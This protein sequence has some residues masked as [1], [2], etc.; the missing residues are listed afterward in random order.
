[1]QDTLILGLDTTTSIQAVNWWG[2]D[3]DGDVIGYWVQWT[4][5]DTA[6]FTT[7]ESAVFYLP[8][9]TEFDI[10]SLSVTAVDNDSLCD[11]TPAIVSFPVYNSPPSVEWKLNSLPTSTRTEDSVHYSFTHHSFFW[12][13]YDLDGLQTLT[14][15]YYALDDTSSWN[16]LPGDRR[17]VMLTGIDPGPHR[18][19]LKVKDI[20]GAESDVITFPDPA[21]E[22]SQVRRW[23][24]KEPIGNVL[25]VNDY[26][27]DQLIYEHQNL[28]TGILDDLVGSDGYSVWEDRQRPAPIRPIRSPVPRRYRKKSQQ[29]F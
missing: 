20:A 24:V 29:L 2:D 13:V 11:P 22:D 15:V 8:L 4:Y 14:D 17:D 3:A 10:Y 18:F 12:D 27:N 26:Q 7:E 28:Y 19:F 16:R 9:R 1:M 5:M 21:S 25:I 23:E 6:E